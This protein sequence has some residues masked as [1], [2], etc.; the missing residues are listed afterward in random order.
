VIA[1]AVAEGLMARVRTQVDGDEK[2]TE[3]ATDEPLAAWEQEILQGQAAAEAPAA[4]AP[5]A[6]APAAEAPAAEAPAAEAPAAEAPAAEAPAAE[7]P[8]A[9]A[10]AA[11]APDAA[12][13]A[14]PESTP[15]A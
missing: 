11:E 2:P 1:D 6:E 3:L 5:A 7:A 4:E 8:A 12:P 10:P 13:A 15:Q 14:D 9:E